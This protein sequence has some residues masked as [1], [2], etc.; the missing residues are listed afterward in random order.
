[1]SARY[2]KATNR[3]CAFVISLLV[4]LVGFGLA[5]NT[6]IAAAEPQ[7]T[8]ASELD[9]VLDLIEQFDWAKFVESL[10]TPVRTPEP[11]APTPEALN[12]ATSNVVQWAGGTGWGQPG[13]NVVLDGVTYVIAPY[14]ASIIEGA[15]GNLGPLGFGNSAGEGASQMAANASVNPQDICTFMGDSQG[16]V[17]AQ[18]A[19]FLV[20]RSACPSVEV[21]GKGT[22]GNTGNGAVTALPSFMLVTQTGEIP[23]LGPQDTG[24]YQ[25][26]TGD[27]WGNTPDLRNPFAVVASIISLLEPG[28]EGTHYST[29]GYPEFKP[30]ITYNTNSRGEIDPEGN[31]VQE[32]EFS[33]NGLVIGAEKLGLDL[34][35]ATKQ[36]LRVMAPQGLPGVRQMPVT[37]R[38][39]VED[40]SAENIYNFFFGTVDETGRI[41]TPAQP[42]IPIVSGLM[43]PVEEML[44]DLPQNLVAPAQPQPKTI[45]L[46][47]NDNQITEAA[48]PVIAA[49]PE[50]F[51]APV[52]QIIDSVV[53]DFVPEAWTNQVLPQAPAFVPPTFDAA[54][55][56]LDIVDAA[57][58]AATDAGVP[59]DLVGLATSF[60]GAR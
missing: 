1:M 55:A 6:A 2:K 46:A 10:V 34:D 23:P 8:P 24:V 7:P 60:L 51:Q 22:P 19:T 32:V 30:D 38:E 59:T 37:P 35:E 29:Q 12:V 27:F 56:Q 48:A 58:A 26:L 42:E 33:E 21:K 9:G 11:S 20:D 18:L 13:P 36:K 43:A 28:E 57:A 31:I 17:V 44:G 45:P 25:N 14:K 47:V 5:G 15:P 52:E 54:P 3:F 50:P 40:P 16:Q 53:P 39:L 41:V 49:L 4:I